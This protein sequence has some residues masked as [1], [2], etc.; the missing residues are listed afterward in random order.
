MSLQTSGSATEPLTE[1]LKRVHAEEDSA[2][3]KRQRTEDAEVPSD[4]STEEL[5][6]I[7]HS[8]QKYYIGDHI[9]V[10]DSAK[11]ASAPPTIAQIHQIAKNT[12]T[13]AISLH[14]VLFS[15]PHEI[16]HPPSVQFYRNTLLKSTRE[17][18]I[19][20]SQIVRHCFVVP[21]SDAVRGHPKGYDE[22]QHGPL[23]VCDCKYIDKGAFMMKIKNRN[24]QYWPHEMS[25]ERKQS[26]SD[27]IEW[28]G[29]PR[30]LEKLGN[31]LEDAAA[32]S[33]TRR[34]TRQTSTASTPNSQ[35]AS[36]PMMTY[37]VIARPPPPPATTQAFVPGANINQSMLMQYQQMMQMRP[38]NMFVPGSL[39]T[40]AQ[41][42]QAAQIAAPTP[43]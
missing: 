40:T 30:E 18:Q 3:E 15:H 20:P 21:T 25:E 38:P 24:R 42:M 16:V 19:P 26:L 36:T 39:P 32:P 17:A 1:G 33:R 9:V 23:Y 8:G 43:P 5:P 29:G 14:I 35:P 13:G 7:E 22:A 31:G 10:S 27:I 6:S 12:T 34:S 37:P 2:S 28:P 41:Y 4:S 11:D